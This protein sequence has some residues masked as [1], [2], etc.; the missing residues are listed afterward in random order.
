MRERSRTDYK[1]YLKESQLKRSS[2][3]Q[4]TGKLSSNP[5]IRELK[6]LIIK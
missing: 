5:E 6:N 2:F 3:S 1:D 4:S